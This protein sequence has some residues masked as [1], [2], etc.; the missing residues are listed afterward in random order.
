MSFKTSKN[1]KKA[2]GPDEIVTE[3]LKL[4]KVHAIKVCKRKPEQGTLV[5]VPGH[6]GIKIA[7]KKQIL[8][9]I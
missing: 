5:W 9:L 3:V 8:L 4:S 1:K 2:T 7:I 6:S